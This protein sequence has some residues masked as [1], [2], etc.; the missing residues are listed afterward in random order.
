MKKGFKSIMPA[1]MKV[2]DVVSP[3]SIEMRSRDS[4]II[5]GVARVLE[6]TRECVHLRMRN[7]ES[8]ELRGV[9]LCCT[10]FGNC[11]VEV[12]GILR[13]IAFCGG[14]SDETNI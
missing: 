1:I 6:S 10:S 5:C 11:S 13:N 14:I 3:F 12:R 2:E 4:V 9:S 8:L 7:G